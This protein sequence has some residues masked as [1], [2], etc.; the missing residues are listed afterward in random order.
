M[1]N[2]SIIYEPDFI[3][4]NNEL[5]T[6][7][8][9]YFDELIL[10]S[11][12]N[13]EAELCKIIEKK[14]IKYIEKSRYIKNTLIPLSQEGVI[15]LYNDA[16]IN[17][18]CPKSMELELGEIDITQVDNKVLFNFKSLADNEMT[19][20]VVNKFSLGNYK[21]ADLKRFVNVCSLSL[22]YNIPVIRDDIG[23]A[24]CDT[25][26]IAD[27]LAIKILCKLALPRMS[28]TNPED[29]IK[30]RRELKDELIEFRAGILDITYLLYQSI[31][32]TPKNALDI[33]REIDILI[34]TKVK[35]AIMSLEH[36]IYSNKKNK[37]SNLILH[38]G[39]FLISGALL[40]LGLGDKVSTLS[41]SSSLLQSISDM[42][43]IIDKPEDK[44]ASYIVSIY[45]RF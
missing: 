36:K 9:V 22:E 27:L 21:V 40:A 41:N 35:A 5:L 2:N 44:I 39:K 28:A 6:S 38:G 7:L 15:T 30:I 11:N 14:D 33:N 32:N 29:I 24:L 34:D 17:N 37:F 12:E 4:L 3:I 13:I 31:K 1:N 23:E 16:E 10:I 43:S 18:L 42:K 45:D 8:C 26:S 25:K 19:K 20:A